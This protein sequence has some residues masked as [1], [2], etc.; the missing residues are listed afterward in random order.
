M[1]FE[2]QDLKRILHD[3]QYEAERPDPN[4]ERLRVKG[5]DLIALANMAIALPKK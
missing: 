2:T 1:S 4:W 5:Y 3:I